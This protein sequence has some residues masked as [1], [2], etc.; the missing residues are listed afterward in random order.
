MKTKNLTLLSIVVLLSMSLWFSAS[1]VVPQLAI[2]WNLSAT[3]KA[4]MTMSVQI[5][6]VVG[7]LTS[8]VFNWADRFS[9]TNLM[10]YNAVLGAV[11]NAFIPFYSGGPESALIFRFLTGASLAGV[12]PPAM[13]VVASWCKE[14][15]GRGIGLL[16]GAVT[17]GS[18]LPHL[19]NALSSQVS[20]LPNWRFVMV[21]TSLLSLISAGIAFRLIK[22]GPHLGA[23]AKFDWKQATKG[24][25]HRPTRLVN[26]GY[27]G[28]MWELYAVWAWVPIMLSASYNLAGESENIALYASF[29]VFVAGAAGSFLAGISA[30]RVGRTKITS[31]SLIASGGCCL[32][33][34][35]LFPYPIPLTIICMIWGFFVIS[36]SAQFS[37]ALTELADPKYVG[38]ALQVQTSLGF[39]VTLITLQI[40][41]IAIQNVGFE[42]AFIILFPGCLF[43]AVSML[44]LRSLPE[45]IKLANGRK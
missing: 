15:R 13:K 9:A 38:T 16:V 5:G 43:G 12:Y 30:D 36:D 39:L 2:E 20:L 11:V 22:S 31:L 45:S 1:A 10:A 28:H 4:W 35:F 41:P 29:G 24:L 23:G 37:T 42:W 27:F 7:A 19:L 18:G 14:D 21:G 26:F 6:F 40:I 33:A 3:M 8:A 17:L 34:G 44:K 25:T 32:L